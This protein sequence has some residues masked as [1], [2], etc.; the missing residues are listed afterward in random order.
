[1]SL[2]LFDMYKAHGFVPRI[3]NVVVVTDRIN[4]VQE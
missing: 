4:P 1:M 3:K 2:V